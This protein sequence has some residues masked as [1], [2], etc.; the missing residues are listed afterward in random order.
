MIVD[1]SQASGQMCQSPVFVLTGGRSGSTLLRIILDAHPELACPPE[2]NI[3]SACSYL[4]QSWNALEA[5]Q[6]RVPRSESEPI[7]EQGL[8]PIR[9]VIDAAFSGY[10][11]NS[12]K[13]RW[14]EKSPDSFRHARLLAQLYPDAKFIWL[15]RHCMDVIASAI[16]AYPWGLPRRMGLEYLMQ[17]PG[18]SVAA[19]GH[20]WLD[21]MRTTMEFVENYPE[22]CYRLRYE[23]LVTA[24]EES[25]ACLFS[26]LGVAQVPGITLDCFST[27]HDNG[28]G[29]KKIW[30]TSEV[31]AKSLGRGTRV[32]ASRLP[33][34]VRTGINEMLEKLNYRVVDRRW[35]SDLESADP[36]TGQAPVA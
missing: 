6:G 1:D 4:M 17:Y 18:N 30:S 31:S 11:K 36:R 15:Y 19:V 35:N 25:I 14:C 27:R 21:Q 8:M 3:A 12:G 7:S 26:F 23:D 10:L 29:D 28:A 13:R 22:R 2:V 16:E 20:Y 32:P 34:P 33:A 5:A 9:G 24:S